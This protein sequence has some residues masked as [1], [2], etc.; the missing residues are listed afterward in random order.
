MYIYYTYI[1]LIQCIYI[2]IYITL[3]DVG[4]PFCSI[5]SVSA[6][7]LISTNHFSSIPRV[8][9]LQE[10]PHHLMGD[11]APAKRRRLAS[12]FPSRSEDQ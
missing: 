1:I 2:Y 4:H 10:D 7:F 9:L 6:W 5:G 11:T 12:L 8:Q 3:V